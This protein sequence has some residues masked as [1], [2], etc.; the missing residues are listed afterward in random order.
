M[1]RTVKR[2][3]RA[4]AGVYEAKAG[5]YIERIAIARLHT[6]G[7][8]TPHSMTKPI[9]DVPVMGNGEDVIT[10]TFILGSVEMN[11]YIYNG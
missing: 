10:T 8:T 7:W 2:G 3:K 1:K 4:G 9:D 11:R 6:H 5:K